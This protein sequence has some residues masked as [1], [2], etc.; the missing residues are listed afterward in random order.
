MLYLEANIEVNAEFSEILVAELAEIGF[1]TFLENENGLLAYIIEEQFDDIA[2]KQ[3][4]ETYA[5]KTN[6]FYSL[7]KIEKQN[8]NEEWE[9]SF[10]P[11]KVLDKILVRASFHESQ[12]GFEHEIIITPK[13]SFGTGHH[14]TTSQIMELQLGVDHKDKSLLDVGTGTGILAILAEKL[15]ANDIKAFDIDEWS[16]E[17]TTE[18]IGLNSCQNIKVSLG[19]IADESPKTYDIVIANINRNI[20]LDEI[21]VYTTFMKS[22][23][24]L[25]LSG[26]YEKDIAEIE[27]CCEANGLKK[28]KQISKKEW[29]AVVFNKPMA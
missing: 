15:G 12:P 20:L 10:D 3:I 24:V 29:A 2:F 21:A 13:M 22:E 1:D 7:K 6:L 8:W 23:G 5:P 9:K 14:E 4:M 19:T 18:N 17:N 28:I 16:V 26:F 25:M 11:I 27:T